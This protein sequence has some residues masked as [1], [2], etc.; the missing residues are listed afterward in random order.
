MPHPVCPS[1]ELIGIYK[2]SREENRWQD[3]KRDERENLRLSAGK[4]GDED[5]E[6]DGNDGE[7]PK[8]DEERQDG[9][10]G[11]VEFEEQQHFRKSDD[12]LEC[13]KAEVAECVSADHLHPSDTADE[14]SLESAVVSFLHQQ[15]SAKY[16][17]Q[18]EDYKSRLRN[19]V[20]SA[21]KVRAES[22]KEGF[23]EENN[24]KRGED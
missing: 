18:E 4:G 14:H 21:G 20:A 5:A 10:D 1:G 2:K 17:A 24:Y 7:N 12:A 8:D 3:E 11:V 9:S 15:D 19:Y 23:H 22:V 16:K 6:H 13:G